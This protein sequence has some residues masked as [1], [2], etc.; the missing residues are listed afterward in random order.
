MKKIFFSLLCVF[1]LASCDNYLDV[2]DDQTNSPFTNQLLP[3]N[4]LAGAIS[5]FQIGQVYF[6]NNFGDKMSNTY[7]INFGFTT[8]DPAFFYNNFTSSSY[9][10]IWDHL[11][12][13]ADNFQDI[14]DDE[15]SKPEYAYHYAA[16]KALKVMA[17]D[18]VISLYG[19]APYTEAFKGLNYPYPKYDDDKQ[20]YIKLLSE[21]DSARDNINNAPVNVKSLGSEDIVFA[22]DTSKWL[23]FINTIELKLLLR[24]S[25]TTDASLITLRTNRFTN[26]ADD[27]I[28]EDVAVNPGYNLSTVT[29]YSPMY[30]LFGRNESNT[31]YTNSRNSNAASLYMNR[32]LGGLINNASITTGITDP[33]RG[34]KFSGPSGNDPGTFPTATVSRLSLYVSGLIDSNGT[35]TGGTLEECAS[36]GSQ[37]DSY[38][39]LAAESS[40]LKAEALVRGYM[41]GG[42]AA[43]K[44]SFEQGISKSFA[45]YNKS[46]GTYIPAALSPNATTYTTN[47]ASK[48]GLGWNGS[49]DKISCIMTQKWLALSQWTGIEPYL[50]HLRTGYPALP[51]PVGTT[52]ANRPYRLIYPNGEYSSNSANVPA[53]S[54]AEM[55]TINSKTPFYYQ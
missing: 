42:S 28:A 48:N 47:I 52:Q 33:R 9:S 10:S 11:Y 2:N 3:N 44:T 6:T 43:A 35:I 4:K 49:A 29:Q 26:L 14:I 13:T 46:V 37:R 27:F 16:A 5:G 8:S 36:N 31:A 51:L 55:F 41:P 21:L 30:R 38:L 50:D 25:K 7:G 34:R 15:A 45:F 1:S 39:M 20:I 32:V 24:L 17:M 18:Y 53:L 22:G 12:L 54:Q 40:F 23:K 19:D